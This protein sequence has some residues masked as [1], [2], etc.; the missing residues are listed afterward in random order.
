MRQVLK[1]GRVILSPFSSPAVSLRRWSR[2]KP[3]PPSKKINDSKVN[4]NI[5]QYIVKSS[6]T[7][8]PTRTPPPLPS[9]PAGIPPPRS[10]TWTRCQSPRRGSGSQR[11]PY[12]TWNFFFYFLKNIKF[13][14][15]PR[16][17][18]SFSNTIHESTKT[19]I[20]IGWYWHKCSFQLPKTFSLQTHLTKI[21]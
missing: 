2:H 1:R 9:L 19:S 14:F 5:V 3:G 20:W 7:C 17:F 6:S 10:Q 12:R 21:N 18:N 13:G 15:R 11:S 8:L 4:S 16:V